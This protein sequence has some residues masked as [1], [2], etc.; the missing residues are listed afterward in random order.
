[1]INKDGGHYL[2]KLFFLCLLLTTL[3]SSKEGHA[4]DLRMVVLDV[5]MGQ[6]IL[7]VQDGHGLLVDTGLAEYA[8]HVLAR[9]KFY[10]VETLDYLVLS[11]LHGDHAAGYAQIR[12]A[13]PETAVFDN[14][15]V[16]EEL[17]PSELE[18][19]QEIHAALGK[20]PM[21][22][23]LSAGDILSWQGHQLQVLWPVLRQQGNL[24]HTSLVLLLSTKQGGKALI[25]GDVDKSVE[26]RLGASL[27][28][29]LQK[30][31][32]DLYI[33]AHHGAVDSCDPGFLSILRPQASVVSVGKDN[34]L[35]YPSETSLA[36]LESNS[37]VVQRTDED[38][39]I[40]YVLKP[41][42]VVPCTRVQ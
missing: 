36:V 40:C 27:Q 8:P 17:D 12:E 29:S 24:N 18:T 10:G 9:M 37:Q 11:H 7:L 33:A 14:C 22:D 5:G 1:M 26:R 35:G 30:R 34:P 20:D 16:P 41:E 6:S 15:H 31:G 32:V 28:T 21:R 19:F 23:C 4:T 42:R 2:R 3:F 39:E 38:G 13:W 25:M